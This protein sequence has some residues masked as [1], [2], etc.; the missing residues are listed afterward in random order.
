MF[1]SIILTVSAVAI[2]A[3]SAAPVMLPTT[4]PNLSHFARTWV[5]KSAKLSDEGTRCTCTSN[6]TVTIISHK[7]SSYRQIRISHKAHVWKWLCICSTETRSSLTK[8]SSIK[9]DAALWIPGLAI[10]THSTMA[11]LIAGQAKP[12][13]DQQIDLDKPADSLM[14]SQLWINEHLQISFA[15]V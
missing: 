9:L 14:Q 6:L 3:T 12:Q 5:N 4:P 1:L 7:M 15:Q 13:M 10:M 11:I 8:M 2:P